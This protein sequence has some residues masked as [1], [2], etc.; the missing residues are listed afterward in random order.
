MDDDEGLD[1]AVLAVA[2][3]M[4]ALWAVVLVTWMLAI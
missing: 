3:I 2:V 1:G 4:A